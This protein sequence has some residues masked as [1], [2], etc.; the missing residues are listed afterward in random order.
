MKSNKGKQEH[1]VPTTAQPENQRYFIH[2]K[3]ETHGITQNS[4]H[5]VTNNKNI[6]LLSNT[7]DLYTNLLSLFNLHG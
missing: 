6:I 5:S 1:L 4:A 7:T 2:F 3:Q